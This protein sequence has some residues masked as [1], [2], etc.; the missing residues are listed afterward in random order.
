VG[1]VRVDAFLTGTDLDAALRSDVARGLTSVPKE[2]PPKYFYDERGSQLFDEITRLDEY[3]PTPREREILAAHA[4][5]VAAFGADTLVELGSGTSDKTRVLLSAMA[6]AGHLRGFIPFDVDE[7]TLRGATE[8]ISQEYPG[9][10]VHGIVGDFEHHLG[11]IPVEGQRVIAFLGGT[12]GN[13]PPAQ[14]AAF[15][16]DVA[17][18]M[19]AGDTF[20]LGTDLVKDID[21]LEAAYDDSSG[22]TAEFNRNVL[23][24][25]NRRLGADFVP[26]RFTHVARF[27]KDN[28]WIEMLLRSDVD[29]TVHVPALELTVEFVQGEEMRTEISAKF[30][31]PGVESELAGAGLRMVEWWTDSDGDFALSLSVRG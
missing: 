16:S 4:A 12:I 10:D 30:R 20:I 24:V 3:Y 14:R 6:D 23:R 2:L 13:L 9:I 29:H 26:E 11:R 7:V 17:H 5:D 28:E 22:V 31:R 21:R 1:S 19:R 18:D 15:L 25:V 8:A 27:D